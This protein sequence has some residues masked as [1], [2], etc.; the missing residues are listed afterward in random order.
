MP[1]PFTISF[2]ASLVL[3]QSIDDRVP[4]A[5]EQSV[6]RSHGE[7]ALKG[8]V[9]VTRPHFRR[10]AGALGHLGHLDSKELAVKEPRSTQAQDT[11]SDNGF[12]VFERVMPLQLLIVIEVQRVEALGQVPERLARPQGPAHSLGNLELGAP[13][14]LVD[15][16]LLVD[17]RREGGGR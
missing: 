9:L 8:G 7:G 5:E 6:P 3:D 4:E 13:V 12:Q 17:V 11:G 16:G 2:A 14:V 10:A 15:E 1:K